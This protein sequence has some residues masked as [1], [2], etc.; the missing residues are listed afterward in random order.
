MAASLTLKD[1]GED[2]ARVNVFFS[3]KPFTTPLKLPLRKKTPLGHY[4][5]LPQELTV[6]LNATV[7]YRGEEPGRQQGET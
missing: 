4:A 3:P 2:M 5:G 7:E 1:R 6:S